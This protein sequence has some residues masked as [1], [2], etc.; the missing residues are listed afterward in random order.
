MF[1]LL[2]YLAKGEEQPEE[3]L[4]TRGNPS[5]IFLAKHQAETETESRYLDGLAHEVSAHSD[6]K[7]DIFSALQV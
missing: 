4:Y 3:K 7:E 6:G 5:G 1:L 2:L